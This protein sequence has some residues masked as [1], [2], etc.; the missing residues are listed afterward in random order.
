MDRKCIHTL[1][2]SKD[3][4]VVVSGCTLQRIPVIAA[5]FIPCIL[6]IACLHSLQTTEICE[7]SSRSLWKERCVSNSARKPENT[8]ASLTAKI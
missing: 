4:T 5:S 2:T 7:K 1:A 8:C 3:T 6:K